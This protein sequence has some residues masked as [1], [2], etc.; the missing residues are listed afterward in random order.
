MKKLQLFVII[1]AAAS[2]VFCGCKSSAPKSATDSTVTAD[3]CDTLVVSRVSYGDTQEDSTMEYALSVDYPQGDDSLAIGAR[4]LVAR[5]LAALYMPQENEMEDEYRKRYPAYKGSIDNGQVLVDFYGKGSMGYL[6]DNRKEMRKL[7]GEGEEL[8]PLYQKA[9]VCKVA[10]TDRYVTFS[11]TDEINMGGAH[12][13][14][15][16]HNV[17]LSKRTF[18]PV[19]HPV[20]TT[21]VKALQPLL[22]KGVLE[23]MKDAGE[24]DATDATLNNLLTLELNGLIPL[25]AHAPYAEGDSLCFVYQQYEIAPY[26]YGLVNFKIAYKDIKP[27]LSP[28]GKALF[29]E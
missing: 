3:G 10:E 16:S 15:R 20:D 29:K 5:E 4:Q 8:P 28:E 1:A 2:F 26:A 24:T 19:D 21:Q 9:T 14:F 23:Y 6:M 11:I 7:F 27:Y 22:R 18:A 17:N 25:P 12:G 13:A